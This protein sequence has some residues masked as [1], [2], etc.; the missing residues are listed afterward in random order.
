MPTRTPRAGRRE[1]ALRI[2]RELEAM[3]GR[4]EWVSPIR[5]AR[6]F[7]AL[8]N[9]DSAFAWLERSYAAREPDMIFTAHEPHFIPLRGDVRFAALARRIAAGA[10][11]TR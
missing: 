10:D 7:A 1:D 5:V 6:I 9:P 11:S 8:R 3:A 2:T 4:G